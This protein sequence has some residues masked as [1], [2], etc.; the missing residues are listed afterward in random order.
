MA[1]DPFIFEP[2]SFGLTDTQL[3]LIG[4]VAISWN[5]LEAQLEERI[6]QIAKWDKTIGAFV[7][8]H[9]HNIPRVLLFNNLVNHVI[10]DAHLRDYAT[11]WVAMFDKVR[12]RR[13]DVVHALPHFN[14]REG[15]D[16]YVKRTTKKG[17]GTVKVT[18]HDFDTAAVS[19]IASDTVLC[20]VGSY[21]LYEKI[22]RYLNGGVT[23]LPADDSGYELERVIVARIQTRLT[24][25]RRQ[26][27][28]QGNTQ[29]QPQP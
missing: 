11:T 18:A 13:N 29:P 9:M 1:G 10:S 8:T 4:K 25:L 14:I 6:W 21:V 3:R 2:S 15:F 7:T 16:T 17:T 12:E 27:P 28:A 5:D 23:Q 26:H 20:S 24:E 22:S 19:L